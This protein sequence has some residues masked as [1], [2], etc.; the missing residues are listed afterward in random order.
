MQ[1]YLGFAAGYCAVR[2]LVRTRDAQY[3]GFDCKQQERVTRPMLVSDRV[4][5]CAI[6]AA[7]GPSMLPLLLAKDVRRLEAWAR[8]LDDRL[9]VTDERDDSYVGFLTYLLD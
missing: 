4:A 9:Y 6:A 2:K 8:G 5:L 3:R 1:H 7:T